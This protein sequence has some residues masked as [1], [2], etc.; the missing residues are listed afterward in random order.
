M[1]ASDSDPYGVK[2]QSVDLVSIFGEEPK[3]SASGKDLA[4]ATSQSPLAQLR[5][6]ADP[7]NIGPGSVK[8]K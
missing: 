8:T 1:A 3:V 4:D 6:G 5:G 7:T 2:H